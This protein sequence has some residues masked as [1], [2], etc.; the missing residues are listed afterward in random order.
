[1]PG[2]DAVRREITTAMQDNHLTDAEAKRVADAALPEF[3]FEVAKEVRDLFDK[4]NDGTHVERSPLSSPTA[5]SERAA[6]QRLYG[7]LASGSVPC[8]N[9]VY[10]KE[11][12]MMAIGWRTPKP[13][14]AGPDTTRLFELDLGEGP[15]GTARRKDTGFIDV[16]T[17]EVYL[18]VR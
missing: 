14:A 17:N 12:V 1:M 16:E 15:L 11:Q 2:L 18:R 9:N 8:S 6:A 13:L 3:T 5:T 7:L 4:V 10:V